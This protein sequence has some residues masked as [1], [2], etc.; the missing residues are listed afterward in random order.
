MKYLALYTPAAGTATSAPREDHNAAME[1]LIGESTKAGTLLSTG[2]ML[3]I[4]KGGARLRSSGGKISLIDG[5]FSEAKEVVAGWA[6]LQYE[7][8]EDAIEGARQ[9]LQVAG[10]GECDLRQIMDQPEGQLAKQ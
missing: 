6:V 2:G 1:K 7:T 10:D 9:F 8:R 4:S 3:P 5:P